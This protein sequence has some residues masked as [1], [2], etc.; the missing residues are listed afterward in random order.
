MKQTGENNTRERERE[1]ERMSCNERA[2]VLSVACLHKSTVS[3]A[4]SSQSG[5][6][7]DKVRLARTIDA[8][9]EYKT[10][11]RPMQFHS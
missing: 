6:Q 2:R 9:N 1:G 4:V 8:L 5:V 11:I 10:H 7:D 3:V